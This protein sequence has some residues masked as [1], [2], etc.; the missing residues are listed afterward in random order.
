[1]PRYI[2]DWF[3]PVDFSYSQG[4]AYEGHTYKI[5]GNLP[6]I[7]YQNAEGA[8][9][10]RDVDALFQ[11]DLKYRAFGFE[12]SG[13]RVW[14]IRNGVYNTPDDQPEFDG[15]GN[16]TGRGVGMGSYIHVKFGEGTPPEKKGQETIIYV[17]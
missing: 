8:L 12:G 1:L 15:E 11:F 3:L 13:G 17:D 16:A 6:G 14:T 7:L 9:P 5:E 10:E 2:N 4:Y